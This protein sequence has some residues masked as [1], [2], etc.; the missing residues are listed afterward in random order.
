MHVNHHKEHRGASGVGI[1]NQPA[2]RHF[3][4]DV[5]NRFKCL[6]CIWLVVHHQE[7]TGDDLDCQDHNCQSAKNVEEIE[8]FRRVILAHMALKG[9][10]YW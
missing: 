2:Q 10:S 1:A 5:L 3:A 8:V 7:N 6:S 9:L 4:H